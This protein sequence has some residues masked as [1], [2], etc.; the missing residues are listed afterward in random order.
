MTAII[1][2][3]PEPR[4]Q[5]A[6]YGGCYEWCIASGWCHIKPEDLTPKQRSTIRRFQ[7]GGGIFP[8]DLREASDWGLSHAQ[9]QMLISEEALASASPKSR[10][11]RALAAKG[12]I[13]WWPTGLDVDRYEPVTFKRLYPEPGHWHLMGEGN[14]ARAL[15]TGEQSG[16]CRCVRGDR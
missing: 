6:C 8:D 12:L 13:D 2:G 14:D 4:E 7:K 16:L 10:T 15:L 5:A 9:Q 3:G 11:A 1:C